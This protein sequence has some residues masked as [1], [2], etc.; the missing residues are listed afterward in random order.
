MKLLETHLNI[1]SD[2]NST[3]PGNT[4]N[5][6][7]DSDHNKVISLKSLEVIKS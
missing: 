1:I 4:E 7:D 2:K 6:F 3:V 5:Y